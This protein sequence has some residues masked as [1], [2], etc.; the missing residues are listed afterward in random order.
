MQKATIQ[1]CGGATAIESL[2]IAG[3][4]KT[5]CGIVIRQR[6]ELGGI[7]LVARL[8]LCQVCLSW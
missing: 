5:G 3:K 1:P 2:T 4:W 6:I 7:H 8:F